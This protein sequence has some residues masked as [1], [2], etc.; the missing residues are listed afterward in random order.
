MT[1]TLDFADS[2][3]SLAAVA[4]SPDGSQ[5]VLGSVSGV[6]ALDA[7]S[8]ALRWSSPES[9]QNLAYSP[10]G[11][12]VAVA[13]LQ[14]VV[15]D[16]STGERRWSPGGMCAGVAWSPDSARVVF[17]SRG[18]AYNIHPTA[19]GFEAATGAPQ[20][21]TRRIRH[22]GGIP[23]VGFSC[24]GARVAI[25]DG[26]QVTF[27]NPSSG[28]SI[29][30]NFP[31]PELL[32]AIAWDPTNPMRLAVAGYK[33]AFVWTIRYDG[34]WTTL[35]LPHPKH[36][37]TLA[38]SPDGRRLLTGGD[39]G[40]CRLWDPEERRVLQELPGRVAAWSADGRR[41]LTGDDKGRARVFDAAG[42]G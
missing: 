2:T 35:R 24:D 29:F 22:D 9:P 20:W 14:S 30:E 19:H 16:S 28:A 10:D 4:I 15:L 13:G 5:L 41:I 34:D 7:E 17:G 42:L 31:E 11:A 36:V 39:E 32:H 38:W 18:L 8:G 25:T 3:D 26:E 27:L 12:S 1:P 23:G 37:L 6:R 21:K 33:E 40:T